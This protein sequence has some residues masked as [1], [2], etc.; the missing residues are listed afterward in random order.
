[1]SWLDRFF[2]GGYAKV[3]IAGVDLT[4]ETTINFVTGA[5]GVDSPS[6]ES[7]DVTITTASGPSLGLVYAASRGMMLP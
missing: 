2:V 6:T 5:T 1:M 4:P 7:T 3:Q